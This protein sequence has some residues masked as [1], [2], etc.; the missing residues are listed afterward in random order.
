MNEVMIYTIFLVNTNIIATIL[1]HLSFMQSL[2][3]GMRIRTA[4]SSLLSMSEQQVPAS[5]AQRVI[6]KF[7]TKEGVKPCEILTRLKVQFYF[8]LQTAIT[9]TI[10]RKLEIKQIKFLSYMRAAYLAIVFTKRLTINFTLITFVLMKN[11]LTAVTFLLMDEVNTRYFSEKTLQLQFKSQKPQKA[12]NAKNQIDRYISRNANILLFKHQRLYDL[13]VSKLCAVVGVGSG[14]SSMLHLLLKELN[15]SMG[16]VIL[17]QGSSKYNFPGNLS[18]GL[19]FT[20]LCISYASQ[21]P[22]LFDV[23]V[24][25]NTV[26]LVLC[27]G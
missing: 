16:S 21:E 18:T 3:I 10:M 15:P 26:W 17:T 11:N 27:Q 5:V 1:L 6:I 2:H 24:R 7:L 12:T 4:C 8:Y 23:T 22:W 25:D 20:N 13:S 14:K 9:R 19:Y